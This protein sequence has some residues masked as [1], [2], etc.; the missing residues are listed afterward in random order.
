[1]EF[2]RRRI[3]VA[4]GAGFIGAHLA[5]RL[6]DMG[7]DV[8]LLDNFA[9]LWSLPL[10]PFFQ[11]SIDH[12][13]D[14]LLRGISCQRG[15]LLHDGDIARALDAFGPEI[16]VNLAA[17]PLVGLAE[18]HPEEAEASI[19][20]PARA[21]VKALPGSSVRRLVHVSSSM[22]YG[23]FASDPNPEDAPTRPLGL[24]GR[25]KLESETIVQE[26]LAG[27]AIESVIVRP[28]GVYGPT[29]VN[30]RVL[31]RFCEG[32]LLG[33]PLRAENPDATAIDFTWVEDLADGLARAALIPEAASQVFNI[34]SG[35]ARTLSE[36]LRI[37][38]SLNPGLG[39]RVSRKSDPVRPRRGALDIG[40][41]RA[42]LGLPAPR[43]LEAGLPAYLEFLAGLLPG[44]QR[45]SGTH[46]VAAG[47]A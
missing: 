23:H 17:L 30:G 41:A 38:A 12:R 40:K 20:G 2:V 5:R 33:M 10:P 31:Q 6:A 18:E 32:A 3:L 21:L 4:G 45:L 8:R 7:H 34:A 44:A 19:A 27:T 9:L 13:T 26:G 29:D 11:Y 39:V 24:Y 43:P 36:A 42:I 14:V 16:L 37:L 35:T 15:N 25:Y 22:V 1:M 47:H 46:A 28:S